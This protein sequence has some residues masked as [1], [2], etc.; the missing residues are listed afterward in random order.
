[1]SATVNYDKYRDC[2]AAIL[3]GHAVRVS[4]AT[5]TCTHDTCLQP[6]RPFRSPS[7]YPPYIPKATTDTL[8]T[9]HVRYLPYIFDKLT[10]LRV[11]RSC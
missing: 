9:R 3:E 8:A 1:M 2:D 11:G 5:G 10:S 7:G 6:D 4:R